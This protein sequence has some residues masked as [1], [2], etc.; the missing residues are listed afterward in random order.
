MK[1][2]TGE[3]ALSGACGAA[4]PLQR[5]TALVWFCLLCFSG[6]I[7]KQPPVNSRVKEGSSRTQKIPTVL[8]RDHSL[9]WIHRTLN[10]KSHSLL[11][12]GGTSH[13]FELHL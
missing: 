12:H 11:L 8:R 10:D 13:K 7:T 9:I 3:E 6:F 1:N 4:G 2:R 5:Q